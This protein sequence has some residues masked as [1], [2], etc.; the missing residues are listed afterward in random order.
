VLIVACSDDSSDSNQLF[1]EKYDGVVW[2][3][4]NPLENRNIT[5][6]NDISGII[7][8]NEGADEDDCLNYIFGEPEPWDDIDDDGDLITGYQTWTIQSELEDSM[9]LSWEIV[10][11]NG[12]PTFTG[13]ITC[14]VSS[15][16]NALQLA[17][18]GEDFASYTNYTIAPNEF[19]CY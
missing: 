17:F 11:N 16:G 5:F 2:K 4:D 19:P 14:T 13:S 10:L 3:E 6:S 7:F 8:F 1:M 18:V 9:V 15:G 12:S